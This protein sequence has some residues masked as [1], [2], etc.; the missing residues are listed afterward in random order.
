M[1]KGGKT[2]AEMRVENPNFDRDLERTFHLAD[3]AAPSAADLVKEFTTLDDFL[4]AEGKRYNEHIRPIKERMDAIKAKLHE[5]LLALGSKDKQSISTDYGT[6]YTSTIMTP[7]IVD[8]TK[9][10]DLC[11][12][13]W[14]AF[15]NEM[16]QIGAPQKDAV[17]TYLDA[18]NGS[19][20]AGVEISSF[21]R[22]N[23]RRS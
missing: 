7:K 5:M 21:V 9:F 4:A 3:S 13:N 23:I 19:L 10:L 17:R 16:L 1:G 22:I 8:R 14:D 20:P 6:V 11:L 15:G 12:D 18:N 2:I